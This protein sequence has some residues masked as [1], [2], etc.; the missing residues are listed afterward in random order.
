MPIC[1]LTN[2][3]FTNKNYYEEHLQWLRNFVVHNDDTS[4]YMQLFAF[5][6]T[7]FNTASEFVDHL[8]GQLEVL[9]RYAHRCANISPALE[10]ELGT[11]FDI[12]HISYEDVYSSTQLPGLKL[13]ITV[14]FNEHQTHLDLQ[15]EYNVS[16]L[17]G[18]GLLNK[19]IAS[20][21][22]EQLVLLLNNQHWRAAGYL[23]AAHCLAD[24]KFADQAEK[25]L[26]QWHP[27]I[28]WSAC[29]TIFEMYKPSSDAAYEFILNAVR[30]TTVVAKDLVYI[31]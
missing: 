12:T 9:N 29:L 20:P 6:K 31:D 19:N 14:N 4:K 16:A 27:S 21:G 26:T 18:L 17:S 25:L 30:D 23:S 11:S 8:N 1:T 24:N 7:A 13:F 22:S 10:K 28:N 5:S 2:I 3:V 15:K